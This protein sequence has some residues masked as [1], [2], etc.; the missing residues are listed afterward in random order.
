M[1][2]EVIVYQRNSNKFVTN[3]LNS[4]H[5]SFGFTSYMINF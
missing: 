4:L 5:I 3:G 1:C 2:K